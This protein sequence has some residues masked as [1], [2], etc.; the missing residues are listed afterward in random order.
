MPSKVNPSGFGRNTA[1]ASSSSVCDVM[2]PGTAIDKGI[3]W[4]NSH[5][6]LSLG[7]VDSSARWASMKGW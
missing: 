1:A 4:P 6:L 7:G 2:G 3:Q 5:V